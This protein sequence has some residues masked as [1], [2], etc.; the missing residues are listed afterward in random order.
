MEDTPLTFQISTRRRDAAHSVQRVESI[1][2]LDSARISFLFNRA[3]LGVC[4]SRC[5]IGPSSI[6]DRRRLFRNLLEQQ[7]PHCVVLVAAILPALIHLC[8]VVQQ[9]V[10]VDRL[11]S[12]RPCRYHLLGNFDQP[13]KP[14]ALAFDLAIDLIGRG[15]GS[16]AV[17]AANGIAA[18][19]RG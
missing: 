14:V 19:Q 18:R 4:I 5:P 9:T 1:M 15:Q 10:R 7:L 2:R 13:P 12:Q 16:S 17:I 3:E 6:V 8:Q 11:L